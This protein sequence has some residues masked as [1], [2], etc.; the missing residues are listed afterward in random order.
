VRDLGDV[1]EAVHQLVP[2][3]RIVIGHG[4]MPAKELE[5]TMLAFMRHEADVL[6]ATTIIESGIDIPNANTIIINEADRFG[7]A[8]LHQLRGRVGR[9]RHRAY[10]YLLLP[11]TRTV[12]PEARRRL[13]AVES[14]SMLGAGFRIALRDLELRG[15]GNLLGPEQSGHIAAV[16]YEMYCRLLEGAVEDLK[17][18]RRPSQRPAVL[19]FGWTGYFPEA[20]IP[21]EARRLDGY[22]RLCQA[23]TWEAIEQVMTDLQ[24]AYGPVPQPA[25]R[26]RSCCEIGVLLGAAGVQ[27]L[28]RRERDLV[29]QTSRPEP[30]LAAFRSLPGKVR[31][32]GERS[33]GG[34][35]EV[36]WRPPT[37]LMRLESV[38]SHLSR[39]L[40]SPQ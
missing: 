23:R 31:R 34:T 9:S 36:W 39:A 37:A 21:G 8:D 10:C 32:V 24:S 2:D 17:S 4:Q 20:W 18:G 38:A 26:L 22:R 15:A 14:F 11:M 28:L 6:V 3:A 13:Q 7:L 1:A 25:A 30:L 12:P 19:D 5:R 29:F 27:A 40:E 35:G 16:G 33:A